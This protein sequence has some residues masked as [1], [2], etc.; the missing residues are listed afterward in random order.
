MVA[1]EEMRYREDSVFWSCINVD[2]ISSVPEKKK[3]GKPKRKK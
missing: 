3:N 2:E 1:V